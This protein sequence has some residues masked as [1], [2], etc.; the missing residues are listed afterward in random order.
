MGKLSLTSYLNDER[1]GKKQGYLLSLLLLN[2][3]LKILACRRQDREMKGTH[4]GKEE[5]KLSIHW[6]QDCMCKKTLWA[7]PKKILKL[8]I[9]FI[10][11]VGYKISKQKS[12]VFL[13]ASN[14]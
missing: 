1:W 14:N 8:I 13:Y 9:D 7:V 4:F 12:I 2:I 6:W 10:K 5:I 3:I 11:V